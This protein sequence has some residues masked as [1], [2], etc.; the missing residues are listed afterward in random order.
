MTVLACQVAPGGLAAY[1][2]SRRISQRASGPETHVGRHREK[3]LKKMDQDPM[4]RIAKQA[5]ESV[6]PNQ[7]TE[8]MQQ[9]YA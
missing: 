5:K 9:G 7:A 6:E 2:R 3:G 8:I 1:N 4:A